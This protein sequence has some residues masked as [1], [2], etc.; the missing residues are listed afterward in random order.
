MPKIAILAATS[1]GRE[2]ALLLN[3]ELPGSELIDTTL[4]VR[5]ALETAWHSFDS[6]I[7]V[8]A[9]GIAVRCVSGLCRSKYY[10]PCIVVVD[11]RGGHAISLLSGHIGGANLLA[12]KVAEISG[13]TAVITTASDVT[14]H[15]AVDLWAVEANLTVVNPD[16]IAST[17]AK[18]IQQGFLK[19]YQPSD[20]IN[21]FPKDFHPCTKQQDADIVIAL[22]PDTESGLKLI[23]RVRYIGFGCR[24]GT[25][26]NE[27]RQAIA[28]LETQD[29]L[30]LRSVGGA[31]S[32]DLK[33][34]EQGLLELAAL[35][36]WPLR[37]FT[38]EQIGSV[39][40]SEKSEIVHRK[41]GVFGVCES[42]AILAASGKNQSGRLI[43]KK[44]K[45]ER[46]T[47]AVA[48]TKY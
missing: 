6:I 20:F 42:A 39:P 41:I 48:E 15:T 31:A 47:A 9:T 34:D 17:S 29:G 44:R 26:I 7:C 27:F 5:K 30:D 43:I 19:V 33:N 36:N 14:G 23:P 8:M 13:G 32:I 22:V 1:S 2:I 40:G 4:G 12:E 38:K 10:D 21:S 24:R 46:I 3:K 25:T 35:F 37:F 16:K 45:W 28:D 18:L 11:E